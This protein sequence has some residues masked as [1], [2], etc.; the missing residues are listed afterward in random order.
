MKT[1][2]FFLLLAINFNLNAQIIFDKTSFD[3]EELEGD[4]QRFVDFYLKN[5]SNKEV[6]ILS[7][8]PPME[9][10]YIIRKDHIQP[11]STS[12]IR[13]HIKQRK[14][15]KFS[16]KIPVY[17][18][19][20]KEPTELVVSGKILTPPYSS[21]FTSCPTFGQS[22]A[23]GNPMDFM[24]TVETIDKETGKELGK[25][26]VAIIQNGKALG[27]WT[28][29]KKGDLKI[30]LPLGITY[31]YAHYDGYYP[32]E[33]AEY[34]NFKNN[35]IV[36]AL[37]PKEQQ[38][39]PEPKEEEEIIVEN[40]PDPIE[41]EKEERI[42]IIEETPEE[43]VDLST[44]LTEEKDS[45]IEEP[46][47]EVPAFEKLDKDN[48]DSQY[49]KPINVVF[50]LDVS[51]SMNRYGREELLKYS[52]D[53]LIGMLRPEDKIGLVS[54]SSDA[55]VLLTPTAGDRKVE[56]SKIVEDLRI[57]GKTAGGKGIKL[58][59]KEVRRNMIKDGK[60]QL[61]IITDGAFNQSS[62]NYQRQIEKHLVKYDISLS[63]VGIKTNSSSE[64]SMKEASNLGDGRFISI[65]KLIDA[66][67]KLK[68]EI[69]IST[70]I[71][72]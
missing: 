19:N 6:Y 33:E 48:F 47:V 49:F 38:P 60:N 20:T 17:T 52:L 44:I 32:A 10:S 9:A 57:S 71:Q 28:T 67:N 69:R 18:S 70:Y 25:A 21:S 13:V 24:L 45:V 8:N 5:T 34:V 72:Q 11:D 29:S 22:P 26:K 58:G 14:K 61:I 31:F 37:T 65:D 43:T 4:S 30:K 66:Q 2:I 40:T 54:Y 15:G 35:R 59:Y 50:V 36:L 27:N 16:Y 56:I 12:I 1:I 68:Q 53:Q 51:S 64:I 23:Q 46:M 63:V 39:T 41:E 7:V 62:G 3:F 55:E 42:I